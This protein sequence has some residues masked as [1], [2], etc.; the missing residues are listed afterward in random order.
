M[1]LNLLTLQRPIDQL[2]RRSRF[3]FLVFSSNRATRLVYLLVESMKEVPIQLFFGFELL[4]L[5][6]DS[7][8]YE[9]ALL[10]V[11]VCRMMRGANQRCSPTS[12]IFTYE[13][14]VGFKPEPSLGRRWASSENIIIDRNLQYRTMSCYNVT[15]PNLGF[16]NLFYLYCFVRVR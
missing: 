16:L 14:V 5:N 12:H 8:L 4:L 3:L 7:S 15:E 9:Y 10:L 2:L 1:C 6:D 11:L 13:Y